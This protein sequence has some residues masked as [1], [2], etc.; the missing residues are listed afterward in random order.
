K[1]ALSA[2]LFLYREVLETDLPWLTDLVR[3]KERVKV[4]TVLSRVERHWERHWG[5]T[6]ITRKA[7]PDPP[8]GG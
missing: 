8:F 6:T 3:P 2:I 5:Q 7:P 1:Q 4:P